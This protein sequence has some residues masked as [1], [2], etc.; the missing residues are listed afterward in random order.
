MRKDF[1]KIFPFLVNFVLIG[2]F[3]LIRMTLTLLPLLTTSL[4]VSS[5]PLLPPPPLY[6]LDAT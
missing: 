5:L 2:N 6:R 4:R 1:W 3:I